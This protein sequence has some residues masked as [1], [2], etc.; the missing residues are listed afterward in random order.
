MF[1]KVGALFH[2]ECNIDIAEKKSNYTKAE[3]GACSPLHVQSKL[4][5][6]QQQQQQQP[7]H[8]PKGCCEQFI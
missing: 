2:K 6:S 5:K 3:G 1:M 7:S 8:P 4:T